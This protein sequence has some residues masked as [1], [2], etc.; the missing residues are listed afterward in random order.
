MGIAYWLSKATNTRSEY[1]I[2]IALYANNVYVNMPGCYVIG[3]LPP[4]LFFDLYLGGS[5]SLSTIGSP[6]SI[7]HAPSLCYRV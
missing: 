3:I 6:I 7:F 5:N 4:T 2:L 1:V